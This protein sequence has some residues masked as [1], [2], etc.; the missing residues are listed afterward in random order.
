MTKFYWIISGDYLLLWLFLWINTKLLFIAF[1]LQYFAKPSPIY[2]IYDIMNKIKNTSAEHICGGE[3]GGLHMETINITLTPAEHHILESYRRFIEGLSDYLG[4]GVE[5]V[6]HSLE[7]LDRSVIKIINGHYTGRTEGAPITNLALSM[8]SRIREEG[9]ASH[10]TY[11][12]KNNQG[13]PIKSSTIAIYGEN[14]RV[15]GLVCMNFYLNIPLSAVLSEIYP[16]H[17]NP[18]SENFTTNISDTIEK[19]VHAAKDTIDHDGHTSANTRN[20]AIIALLD[21]QGIFHL[22]DA[23]VIVAQLLQISKNTVYLHLRN[24]QK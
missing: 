17:T 7:N 11:F 12:G 8:L 21:E 23:V 22:K 24:L 20:K 6:L 10:V 2:R 14:Q 5:I 1:L 4:S 9:A 15:I 3:S 19:A 13:E 18:V 16:E